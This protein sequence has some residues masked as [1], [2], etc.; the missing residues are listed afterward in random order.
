MSESKFYSSGPNFEGQLN[1]TLE[2]V[3]VL[4]EVPT[5]RIPTDRKGTL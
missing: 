4:N 5:I 2:S 3:Y 1:D